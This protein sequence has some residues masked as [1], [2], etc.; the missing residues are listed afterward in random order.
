MGVAW[1]NVTMCDACNTR[2][3]KCDRGRV[4]DVEEG[5]NVNEGGR[6]NGGG[7]GKAE[8]ARARRPMKY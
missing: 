5:G 7:H 2:I 6:D 1:S 4:S 8:G 3:C